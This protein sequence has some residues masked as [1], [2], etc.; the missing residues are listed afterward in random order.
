MQSDS[1]RRN[2][3]RDPL[4]HR[5][6]RLPVR[7]S[8]LFVLASS[9]FT[10]PSFPVFLRLLHSTT[11]SSGDLAPRLSVSGRDDGTGRRPFASDGNVRRRCRG[12]LPCLNNSYVINLAYIHD[13]K[14]IA[15]PNLAAIAS[16]NALRCEDWANSLRGETPGIHQRHFSIMYGVRLS[17]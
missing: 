12:S 3:K 9:A 15:T 16:V 11:S 7:S 2:F 8:P 4:W 13:Q 6:H 5:Y 1:R 17:K 14:M 10:T